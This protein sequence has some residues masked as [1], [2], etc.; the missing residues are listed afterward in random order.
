METKSSEG[1]RQGQNREDGGDIEQGPEPGPGPALNQLLGITWS[2]ERL[3]A[4]CLRTAAPDHTTR[5]FSIYEALGF[6]DKRAA[7]Q[8][9]QEDLHAL[10][11]ERGDCRRQLPKLSGTETEVA[12]LE[13]PT[14]LG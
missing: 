2:T 10:D 11:A 3:R 9:Q 6:G 7:R 12:N 14:R 4:S 8:E 13:L 1:E 5:S